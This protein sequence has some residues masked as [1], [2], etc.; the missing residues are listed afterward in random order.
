MRWF[1]HE[2]SEEQ[3]KGSIDEHVSWDK[4]LIAFPI[5]M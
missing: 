5:K 2:F 1:N 3:S 4:P